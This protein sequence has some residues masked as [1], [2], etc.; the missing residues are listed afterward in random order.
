MAKKSANKKKSSKTT[1]TPKKKAASKKAT[2]KKKS[3]APKKKTSTKKAATTKKATSTKKK[4]TGA[5]R[6][7]KTTATKAAAAPSTKSAPRRKK[8]L[9]P[10]G[11]AEVLDD[12]AHDDAV[13][14]S[15]DATTGPVGRK[16]AAKSAASLSSVVNGESHN[17]HLA[18][19][20]PPTDDE[21]RKVKTGLKKKEVEMLRGLLLE[22]RADIL[23]DV[24]SM[25][26]VRQS[27]SGG[28]MSHMPLHMADVGS[29]AYEQEFTLSL[30]ESERKLLREIDEALSRLHDGTYGVCQVSAKPIPLARLEIKPWAKYTIEVVRERERRGLV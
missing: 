27:D 20:S 21:L 24:A 23:G 5:T 29:D 17:G 15:L 28:D 11:A 8:K 13:S 9:A 18:N 7:K 6:G 14:R 3:T 30:V 1:A 26:S 19:A 25:E 12:A 4:T 16:S 22:K 10:Q 2:T